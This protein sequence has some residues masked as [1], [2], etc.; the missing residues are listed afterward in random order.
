MPQVRQEASERLESD[1]VA[2][3]S[4]SRTSVPTSDAGSISAQRAF[5]QVSRLRLR[6]VSMD[7]ALRE[8]VD[9]TRAAVQAA[10][11]V[12]ISLVTP[13]RRTPLFL[14]ASW[15]LVRMRARCP[16]RADGRGSGKDDGPDALP[17]PGPRDRSPG[18]AEARVA[19]R[20]RRP[21]QPR[22]LVHRSL[23]GERGRP[24]GMRIYLRRKC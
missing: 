6:D 19:R 5:E 17:V 24:T 4:A 2:P 12:S 3:K 9:L 18:A 21:R 8:V 15:L 16:H 1:R 20:V 10:D 23:E 14:P 11:E 22:L 7:S 13:E